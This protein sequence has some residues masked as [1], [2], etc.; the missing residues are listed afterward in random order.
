MREQSAA[1]W[2]NL[3]EI[4]ERERNALADAV[5][6]VRNLEPGVV[7]PAHAHQWD[8][9]EGFFEGTIHAAQAFKEAIIDAT[10]TALSRLPG[11]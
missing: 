3:Y 9:E 7:M 6:A 11:K 4:T 2:R 8:G 1:Y 10:T 5:E